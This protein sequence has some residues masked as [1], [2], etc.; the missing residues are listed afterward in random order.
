MSDGGE[1]LAS[2]LVCMTV[3]KKWHVGS[4]L[5]EKGLKFI[6][7]NAELLLSRNKRGNSPRWI[8]II[9][10][11]MIDLA[12]AV[13]L[14]IIFPESTESAIV[15]LFRNR[16]R[17]LE[18]EKLVDRNQYYPLL[19]YLEALPPTYKISNET[20]LKH[21]DGDGSLFQS[22]SA[23]ASAYLST[24]HKACLA[25]LQSLASNCASNGSK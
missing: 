22:P 7:G 4:T 21:V 2:T 8:A 25:Y 11:G 19:S 23:T 9:L 14:E 15:D 20:I 3:L 12:R 16:Q 18:R 6:H 17:I 10:P 5:I 13:G 1:C 24:G